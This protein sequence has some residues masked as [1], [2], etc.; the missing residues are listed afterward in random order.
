M[1]DPWAKKLELPTKPYEM[2][3]R[4]Q[5][6]PT[7]SYQKGFIVGQTGGKDTCGVRLEE[8]PGNFRLSD[9]W[10]WQV[11]GARGLENLGVE[12]FGRSED[13]SSSQNA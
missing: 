11:S 2:P 8:L 13:S 1:G 9:V 12:G 5:R 10:A 4:N 7:T 3:F 6:D